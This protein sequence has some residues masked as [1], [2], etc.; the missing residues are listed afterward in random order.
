MAYLEIVAAG[1]TLPAPV[2]LS[3][4]NELI[5]SANTGRSAD[6]GKMI[7]D[8]VARKETIEVEW[9]MLTKAQFDSI[10]SAISSNAFFTV[11]LRLHGSSS[12]VTSFT[13]YRSE[14]SGSIH[15]VYGKA[16]TIYYG[17]AKCSFIQQ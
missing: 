7:G 1:T 8:V 9:A 11:T 4:T 10:K 2:A 12:N 15:G 6:S 16:G 17:S 14:L 13:S 5:W 3:T